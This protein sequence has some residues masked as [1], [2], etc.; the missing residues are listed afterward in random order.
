[1][2]LIP[3]ITGVEVTF[4]IC[5]VLAIAGA[6]GLITFSK[7]VYSA[8]CLALVMV[9]L[10]VIYASLGAPFL[11]VV[12]IIVYTGAVLMLFLF[13]VMLVGVAANDTPTQVLKG[14]RWAVALAVVGVVALL[15]IAAVRGVVG[16]PVGIDGANAGGNVEG[17]AELIFSRYVIAFEVTAALLIT[18][19]VAAMVLAH[20]EQLQKRVGQAERAAAR[21]AGFAESG[22][23][24]GT[25]PSSG[26]FA[27]QNSIATPALLPDGTVA[28]ESVSRVVADRV[29]I[30]APATLTAAH[31]AVLAGL[32]EVPALA[33]EPA[34]EAVPDDKPVP[35]DEAV[36]DKEP[37]RDDEPVP[38]DEPV[39]G[40]PAPEP[41]TEGE[42]K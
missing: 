4:G 22:R 40:E 29:A 19:A 11:F 32:G 28:A 1:M 23:H 38:A 25:P 39:P 37:V 35:A 14:H 7:P 13:V 18:A 36:P 16:T 15:V 27:R 5:A 20:P 9:S 34:D 42:A 12:Q 31:D 33:A 21:L 17:L 10:A 6:V 24:P 41:M 2:M 30:A 8:L 3:M 26:I